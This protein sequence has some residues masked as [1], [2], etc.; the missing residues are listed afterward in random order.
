MKYANVIVDISLEK[1]DRTFQYR[2]PEALEASLEAGMQVRVPFG[3][4][5]RVLTAYVVELTDE[6][7]WDPARMKEL[8]G[9]VE[10]GIA[11]EGQLIALASWMKR[12]YG[13]TM[14]QALKT[15]LP[16]RRAVQEKVR[17]RIVLA[18]SKEEAESCRAVLSRKHQTARLRLLEALL[19]TG[20]E[21]RQ[22]A[23]GQEAQEQTA[24]RVGGWLDY[25]TALKELGIT[26]Q[27]VKALSEAGILRVETDTMLRNPVKPSD[28]KAHPV[29][30][31]PAQQAAVDGILSRARQGDRRPSLIHGVT[32]SGKTE[33]YME[34]IAAVLEEGRQA[35]VLIPEIA[36]TF[37]TVLRFYRRFGD[38]VSILHSRLSAGERYDQLERAR[39]GEVRVMIGPRSALFTPF[40]RLGIIVIDEE[41]EGSYKSET[42]PRYHARETAIERARMSGAF[43]VLGSAT[44]SVDSY[45]KARTGAY[46][47]YELPMRAP[48]RELPET[49]IIDLREELRL[50]NRSIFS[51]RL[52]ELMEDRLKKGQQ[53]ML[54]LN[55]RGYAGFVSC[56]ACGHVIKCPHC[57]VALSL[58]GGGRMVCHYCGYQ[59]AAVKSCPSCGSSYIGAF[60][61]GTQ[62]V[63]ELAGKEFPGARVLRMDFDTTKQKGGHEKILEAFAR[64]EADILV[65]TQM[66]VK[67]HDFPGVTLV[68][69][70]AADLS[71]YAGD[72]RASER[73][74]QLLTQAAGRAGRGSERGTA[75]IQTYSP[76]HYSVQTAAAQDYQGFFEQEMAYRSLMQ[77]PPAA[78]LMALYL[79]SEKE[80]ELEA[81][82]KLVRALAQEA[83]GKTAGS[84]RLQLIGPADAGLARLKDVYRKVLY[85]K[86]ADLSALLSVKEKLEP[87]L[88]REERLRALNI[89]FDMDPV[90]PF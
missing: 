41:H 43:V 4:G 61:A 75:V 58:H 26:A 52:K 67:G 36:L 89:Q 55:R 66:I 40:D 56:R 16:V 44:P 76:E 29:T 62:Q 7:E 70:L 86:S 6:C 54:F 33:I 21:D 69:I 19:E 63:A 79:M 68:G 28:V 59:Q 24:G 34:L 48:G 30:L 1:L 57:D 73:T 82:A 60:R 84:G 46:Q 85:L 64:H 14:N 72:Y 10:K 11:L 53:V 88:V 42:A 71:L 37:Q 15:V 47:L 74:F 50:G 22:E 87:E 32:G 49:E 25:S 3:N 20:R 45:E 5:G 27:T 90:N 77:Y 38:Q 13:S 83:A 23:D 12:M 2:V 35:I 51:A 9:I 81:G 80:E 78:H 17:R 39:K 31:Y 8:L 18:V 65:G